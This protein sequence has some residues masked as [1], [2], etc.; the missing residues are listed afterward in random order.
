MKPEMSS[1]RIFEDDE[2]M[3]RDQM[4]V[5]WDPVTAKTGKTK[6]FYAT[7]TYKQVICYLGQFLHYL[8]PFVT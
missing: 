8:I 3:A 2:V 1:A 7:V 5:C 4:I 6:R